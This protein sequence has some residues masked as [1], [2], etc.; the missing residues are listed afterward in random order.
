MQLWRPEFE[1]AGINSGSWYQCL[2]CL[3]IRTYHGLREEGCTVVECEAVSCMEVR[4]GL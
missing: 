1:L 4:P 3:P 2:D